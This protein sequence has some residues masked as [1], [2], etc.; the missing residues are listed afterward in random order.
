MNA[1]AGKA[2]GVP[3]DEDEDDNSEVEGKDQA[4]ALPVFKAP[5]RNLRRTKGGY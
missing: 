2:N 5:K 1:T 3:E 4:K